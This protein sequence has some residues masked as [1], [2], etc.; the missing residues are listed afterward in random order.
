MSMT[1]TKLV[2]DKNELD[3]L[4]ET[5]KGMSVT[6]QVWSNKNGT[7]KVKYV[8]EKEEDVINLLLTA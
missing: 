3:N 1:V 2:K 8:L 5:L 6:Y 4:L 7:S